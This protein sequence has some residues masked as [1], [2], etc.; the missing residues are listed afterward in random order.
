MR[1]CDVGFSWVNLAALFGMIVV[2]LR[3]VCAAFDKRTVLWWARARFPVLLFDPVRQNFLLGQVNI[4]LALMIVADLTLDLPIPRGIL[5]G[6]AA[7]IKVTPIILIRYLLL[8]RQGRSGVRAI[9]AFAAAG[10]LA[11]AV[12]AST[13]WSY[14]THYIRDPSGPGCCRGSATRACSGRPSA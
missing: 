14:W 8:T 5:V 3:A 2:S 4:I 9:A 11:T 13:S 10:V 1:A 12:N 6:L 7:A